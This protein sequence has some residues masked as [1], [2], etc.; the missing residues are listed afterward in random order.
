MFDVPDNLVIDDWIADE[1][2]GHGMGVDWK[3]APCT[4]PYQ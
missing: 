3:R 1:S 4:G 2:D